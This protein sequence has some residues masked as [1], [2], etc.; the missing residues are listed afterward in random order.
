MAITILLGMRKGSDK[1]E[2]VFNIL[3]IGTI[4]ENVILTL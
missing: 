1:L 2:I 4:S 3:G